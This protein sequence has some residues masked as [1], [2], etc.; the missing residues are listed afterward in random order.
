MPD[1]SRYGSTFRYG[2]NEFITVPGERPKPEDVPIQPGETHVFALS[3]KDIEGWD[4]WAKTNKLQ[5]PKSV[6]IV[7][8]FICFGDG[9][10]WESLNGQPFE[11]HKPPE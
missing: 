11:R 5:Q 4:N 3:T 6:Q 7:F 9:T 10:G 2:R 1:G 8:N